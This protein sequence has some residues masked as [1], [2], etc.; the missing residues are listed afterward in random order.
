M[1]ELEH[2]VIIKR[3]VNEV[4]AFTTNPANS[5]S[6]RVGLLDAKQITAGPMQVGSV[7]EETVQ[8]LG[9]KLTSKV[10]VT[11]LEPDVMRRIRVKL[12][13]LPIDMREEYEATPEGTRLRIVGQTDVKGP[14][15]IAAKAAMSQ[16]KRQLEQELANIKQVLESA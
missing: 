6:W 3:P 9:R 7:I 8:V 13:P 4:F 14:Q 1:I 11:G 2:S 16:V 15:R 10:E 12:G 5:S